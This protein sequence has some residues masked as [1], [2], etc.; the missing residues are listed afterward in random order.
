MRKGQIRDAGETHT[1]NHVNDFE[2]RVRQGAKSTEVLQNIQ[3]PRF[4]DCD[5]QEQ[6]VSHRAN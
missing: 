3:M 1:E 6:F 5:G 2:F 4:W